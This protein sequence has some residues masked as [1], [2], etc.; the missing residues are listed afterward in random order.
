M[1]AQKTVPSALEPYGDLL[2]YCEPYWY[3]GLPTGNFT[4]NHAKFR[5]TVRAF[6]D[7]EILP[8]V[9]DWVAN[10]QH[11]PLE[12][13][14]KAYE[15]G[16]Q[17]V[18]YPKALGGT[19]PDDFDYFYEMILWGEMA[20]GGAGV[21]GQMSINSMALPP[22]IKFGS[23]EMKARVVKD[24]VQGRKQISLMISE[25]SAGSDV[26][27]IQTTAV[28][29]GDKFIV[30][31][32]KKWITGGM[33]ADF[34]T[35]LVRTGG[36]G[37]GGVSLILMER[38]MPG[39]TVRKMETSFDNT[40]STT[41]VTLEDVEVP[42]TNLIGPE[43]KGLAVTLANFAHERFVIVAGACRSSRICYQESLRE[44]LKRKTFGKPLIEHQHVRFKL[45]EMARLIETLYATTEHLAYQLSQKVP[46]RNI[47]ARM[48]LAKVQASKTFEHCA[49][50]AQQLFGGS[51]LVKEGRGK[52]VERLSRDVRQ[53]AI[54]GGS[55]E[56]L[57]LNGLPKKFPKL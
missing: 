37:G 45:A 43:N 46:D 9:D 17:G 25:P 28:R 36:A 7:R 52:L 16:I 48:G 6:V 10:K 30:N 14:R 39:I 56:I 8:Y 20:R 49:R 44:A 55:E 18:L 27:N 42:V 32:L 54:P 51:S 53:T 21:L 31:G 4:Q 33:H 38:S 50:E 1:P 19:Q 35:A 40:H 57:V 12:L 26:A 34:F 22:I 5:D 41:F 24:V 2:D 11:Y 23:E 13:H 3:Q 47:G 15:A 29:K